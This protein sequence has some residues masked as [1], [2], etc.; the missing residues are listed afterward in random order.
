MKRMITALMGLSLLLGTVSFAKEGCC[1]KEGSEC[2]KKEGSK[3]CKGHKHEHK[4]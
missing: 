1:K 4:K 2:C 3:C